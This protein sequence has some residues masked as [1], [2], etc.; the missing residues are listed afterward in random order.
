MTLRALEERSPKKLAH[1][2][3]STIFGLGLLGFV[4]FPLGIVAWYFGNRLLGKY[5]AEP[6]RW[7]HRNLVVVGRTLGIIGAALGVLGLLVVLFTSL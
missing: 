2:D 5:D 7:A 3:T 6:G 1:P 4:I